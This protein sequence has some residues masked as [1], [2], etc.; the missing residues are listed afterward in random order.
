MAF[1]KKILLPV[2]FSLRRIGKETE[3]LYEVGNKK[4]KKVF[5]VEERFIG[6]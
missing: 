2:L 3:E 6:K 4:H 5:E 1:P